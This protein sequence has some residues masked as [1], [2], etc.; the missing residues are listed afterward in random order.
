MK[1][2]Q[3]LK[4][5]G[6]LLRSETPVHVRAL[7]NIFVE[8]EPIE[9][10]TEFLIREQTAMMLVASGRCELVD[11][12]NL[13]TSKSFVLGGRHFLPGRAFVTHKQKADDLIGQGLA[14]AARL[15]GAH[16]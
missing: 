1:T 15:Q 10:G 9:P 12:V 5:Y 2:M 16:S 13:I 7:K 11:P 4:I 3:S 6:D 14:R 8:S